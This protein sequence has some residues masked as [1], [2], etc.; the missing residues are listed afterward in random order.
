MQKKKAIRGG[1][2]D[3]LGII[4]TTLLDWLDLQVA[5]T[6]RVI[7]ACEAKVTFLEILARMWAVGHVLGDLG[8]IGVQN[9]VAIQFH[10]DGGALDSYFLEIPSARRAKVTTMSGCHPVG[11]AM[12]LAC[13]QLGILGIF[14]V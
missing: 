13:I 5:E 7:V 9:D 8:K 11:A 12:V 3:G 10:L 4:G 14:A 6:H 2:P 1:T